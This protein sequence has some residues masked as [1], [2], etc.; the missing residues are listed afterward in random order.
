MSCNFTEQQKKSLLK[1]ILFNSSSAKVCRRRLL[2]LLSM[3]PIHCRNRNS[4]Y[5]CHYDKHYHNMHK[6][7]VSRKHVFSVQQYLFGRHWR[8]IQYTIS[9]LLAQYSLD[10][11]THVPLKSISIIKVYAWARSK[12]PRFLYIT[13]FVRP[14]PP[15][16]KFILNEQ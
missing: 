16:N 4:L 15:Y 12:L 7:M 1:I 2:E 3:S 8:W 14:H 9:H 6:R 13:Y 5:E 10:T 11:I